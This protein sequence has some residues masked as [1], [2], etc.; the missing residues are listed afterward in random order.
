MIGN[1]LK[2]FGGN[3]WNLDNLWNRSKRSIA[4]AL[5]S[6][7]TSDQEDEDDDEDDPQPSGSRSSRATSGKTRKRGS[8]TPSSAA[9]PKRARR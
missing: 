4:A 1:F 7:A 6:P 8:P 2:M 3:D 5:H 9:S